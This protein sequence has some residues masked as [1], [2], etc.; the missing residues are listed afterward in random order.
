[1]RAF[2]SVAPVIFTTIVVLAFLDWL[3]VLR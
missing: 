1:M 2:L 3:L